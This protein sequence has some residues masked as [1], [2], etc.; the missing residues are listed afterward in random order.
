MKNKKQIT[1]LIPVFLFE[2]IESH[3]KEPTCEYQTI[4]DL[5]RSLI[6]DYF[7]ELEK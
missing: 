4:T 1:V 2:K 5:V 6:R 7:K 3:L